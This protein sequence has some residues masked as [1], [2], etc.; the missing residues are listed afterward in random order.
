VKNESKAI[1]IENPKILVTQYIPMGKNNM[2]SINR[3]IGA[4]KGY[5]APTEFGMKGTVKDIK[6]GTFQMK[7]SGV[8]LK[9]ITYSF[10]DYINTELKTSIYSESKMGMRLDKDG[11]CSLGIKI[12]GRNL[13]VDEIK[14]TLGKLTYRTVDYIHSI[15]TDEQQSLLSTLYG[16]EDIFTSHFAITTY[17]LIIT[18]SLGE[19]IEFKNTKEFLSNYPGKID[20]ITD[21]IIDNNTVEGCH[22][23]IGMRAAICVGK[24]SMNLRFTIQ[25]ILFLKSIFNASLRLFSLMWALGKAIKKINDAIPKSNYKKLK[26]FNMKIAIINNA[27]SRLK[28]LDKMINV[29]IE[30][31]KFK[32]DKSNAKKEFSNIFRIDDE[33]NDEIDKSNDRDLILEQLGVDLKSLRDLVEQRIDLIMTKNSEF[34]NVVILILA[35]ISV[36][37]IADVLGFNIFELGTVLIFMIPFIIAS[38]IYI[39]NYIRNFRE[40]RLSEK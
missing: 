5:K 20:V 38:L 28:I 9:T 30:Q 8:F 11:L 7:K 22:I 32:W 23:F 39:K 21:W 6:K 3:H 10:S 29:A 17:S 19:G 33:F 27:L 12:N 18:D 25:N 37:G 2:V 14:I 40:G 26:S 16:V 24:P 35:L 36:I 15:L 1:Y 31:K 34:L 4:H 13:G